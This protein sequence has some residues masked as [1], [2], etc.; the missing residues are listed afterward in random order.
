MEEKGGGGGHLA[1]AACSA[2]LCVS[3]Q[4]QC[5]KAAACSLCSPRELLQSVIASFIACLQVGKDK[6]ALKVAKRKVRLAS[7]CCLAALALAWQ[8]CCLVAA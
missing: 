1:W 7:V 8:S 2:Q 3:P 4:Q 5:S 6:R